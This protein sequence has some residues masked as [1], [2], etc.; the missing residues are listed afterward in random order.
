VNRRVSGEEEEEERGGEEESSRVQERGGCG[1]AP[2]RQRERENK[3]LREVAIDAPS[4]W[5]G[6]GERCASTS[7]LCRVSL[8]FVLFLSVHLHTATQD[9]ACRLF[10]NFFP[11]APHELTLVFGSHFAKNQVSMAKL[12][13]HLMI[14]RESAT[15]ALQGVGA[16]FEGG[17]N[18]SVPLL[19]AP[20]PAAACAILD[21]LAE[22]SLAPQCDSESDSASGSDDPLPLTD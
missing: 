6:V 8:L 18:T 7:D 19:Y 14:H 2:D 21:E 15:A 9:Q 12:Q 1:R 5:L 22:K 20:M 13:G 17:R 3:R 16:L 11:A 4:G 10:S